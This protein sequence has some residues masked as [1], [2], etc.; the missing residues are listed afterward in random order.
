MMTEDLDGTK[1]TPDDSARLPCKMRTRAMTATA[2]A[3]TPM[4]NGK[5]SLNVDNTDPS[6]S[7]GETISR[8]LSTDIIHKEGQRGRHIDRDGTNWHPVF[9]LTL[10]NP[11]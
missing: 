6:S 4:A 1:E 11:S 7:A 8:L 9:H 2:L 10:V 3:A 5:V